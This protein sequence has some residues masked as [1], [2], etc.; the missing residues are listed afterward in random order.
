MPAVAKANDFSIVLKNGAASSAAA[1][2]P[3]CS[4]QRRT[5]GSAATNDIRNIL[6][7]KSTATGDLLNIP[8]NGAASSAGSPDHRIT[9][10]PDHRIPPTWI[11]ARFIVYVNS[12]LPRFITTPTKTGISLRLYFSSE[13]TGTSTV[14][15]LDK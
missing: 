2:G 8:I 11:T 7:R 4:N 12:E 13:D 3:S 10:P 9:G 1:R 6:T 14:A 15:A 5:R